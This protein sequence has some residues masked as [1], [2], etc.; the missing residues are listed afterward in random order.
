M[1]KGCGPDAGSGAKRCFMASTTSTISG[2]IALSVGLKDPLEAEH[3]KELRAIV[4]DFL[5]GV[6][7]SLLGGSL[8]EG[9]E[10][11]QSKEGAI[12]ARFGVKDVD[13]GAFRVLL[14]LFKFF[15][16]VFVPLG[17][18]QAHV[19]GGDTQHNLMTESDPL[20]TVSQ[21]L[22]F[23]VDL[24]IRE[25]IAPPLVVEV[26]FGRKLTDAEMDRLEEE[27]MV[28]AALVQGGYPYGRIRRVS[29]RWQE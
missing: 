13:R 2:N 5:A 10:I 29:R 19:R 23:E 6:R 17:E 22:P 26:E 7:M 8:L 15:E 14:G 24:S 11:S 3:A 25:E 12:E 28:W 1:P 18:M 16:E 21:E 27:M 4:D 9:H 20:P